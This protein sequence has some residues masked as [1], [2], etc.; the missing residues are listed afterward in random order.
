MK[1]SSS[2]LSVCL[3]AML[4]A[5]SPEPAAAQ[6]HTRVKNP[7]VPG[8]QAPAADPGQKNFGGPI[9]APGPGGQRP[10]VR[11]PRPEVKF[12]TV[13]LDELSMSDPFVYPDEKSHTYYLI[14]SGG[15]LYC[16]PSSLSRIWSSL[17]GTVPMCNGRAFSTSEICCLR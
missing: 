8:E 10:P 14:G 12:G 4:V 11:P 3:V 13:S 16:A 9:P 17:I 7:A 2:L 6:T 1:T 5:C 15:R